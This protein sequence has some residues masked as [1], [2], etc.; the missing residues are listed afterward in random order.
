MRQFEAGSERYRLD[1]FL[2]HEMVEIS[3]TR[4][5]R[6]IADGDVVV[7]GRRSLK[8]ARL[9]RG[10]TVQILAVS[11]EATSA[12]PEAIPL[13][14]LF[15]DEDLIAVN[16]PA[17]LLTHPSRT[18][19]SGTLTNGLAYHF[20]ATTGRPIR[21]GLIHRL[22]RDTS[23]IILVAKTLRAHRIVAKAFRE[24][25]V[26]K[27]YTALLS[28]RVELESGQV[29]APIGSDPNVWPHWRVLTSGR[30]AV[31]SYTVLRRFQSH[32][33]VAF[34]PQTGRTHQLRIH[35]ALLG[36]PIVGDAIYAPARDHIADQCGLGYHLLHA[37]EMRFLHPNGGLEIVIEAP[38]PPLWKHV[39]EQL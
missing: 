14:V 15:E 7:N 9:E 10:D 11:S 29:D 1:E 21:A 26:S 27:S 18:E 12:T 23:G 25:R 5:R 31:T 17:G 6:M 28:G 24:R 13:E 22:D 16:K 36:H 19:K 37:H 33:L 20:L 39:L 35:S 30:P 3:V 4:L 32:T 34:T 8:G 2:A 38:L